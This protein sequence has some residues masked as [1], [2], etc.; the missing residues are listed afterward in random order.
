MIEGL[1]KRWTGRKDK[2][3][4]RLK[5]V[6]LKECVNITRPSS[7]S[8][9]WS[10]LFTK[11]KQIVDRDRQYQELCGLSEDYLTYSTHYAETIVY[12]LSLPDHLKTVSAINIGGVAGGRKYLVW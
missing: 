9:Y 1:D 10:N 5:D 12:E 8:Y 11:A 7:L 4:R 3:V 2:V 6:L